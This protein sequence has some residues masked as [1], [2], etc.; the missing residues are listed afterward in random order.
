MRGP[1][2]LD[3][4]DMQVL[5]ANRVSEVYSDEMSA[6]T[7]DFSGITLGNGLNQMS[8]SPEVHKLPFEL[9]NVSQ[10]PGDTK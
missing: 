5:G 8:P 6:R 10:Q 7:S 4:D 2:I 1:K 9:S 3:H